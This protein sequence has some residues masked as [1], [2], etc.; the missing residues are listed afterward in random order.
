ML[1]QNAQNLDIW[2]PL[3]SGA[4]ADVRRPSLDMTPADWAALSRFSTG[5]WISDAHVTRLKSLELLEVVFGQPLLTRLG[6]VTIGL[7]S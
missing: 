4:A 2:A 6:R 5:E 3:G 7:E 1:H